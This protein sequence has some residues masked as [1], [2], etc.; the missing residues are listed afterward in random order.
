MIEVSTAIA[1]KIVQ[2]VLEMNATHTTAYHPAHDDVL[3]TS[4]R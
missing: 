1:S 2:S 3:A 4:Y